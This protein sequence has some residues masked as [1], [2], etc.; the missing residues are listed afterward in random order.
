MEW[1]IYCVMWL[2]EPD[3]APLLTFPTE[4]ACQ[5]HLESLKTETGHQCRCENRRRYFAAAM[6]TSGGFRQNQAAL[7]GVPQS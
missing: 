3:R 1:I 7:E 5:K 4:M 6:I 2:T